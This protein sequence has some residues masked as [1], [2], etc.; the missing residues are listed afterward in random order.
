MHGVPSTR[1]RRRT[2]RWQIPS[3][4]TA[5]LRVERAAAVIARLHHS[6]GRIGVCDERAV[7]FT[8]Q[9]AA[10]WC[11]VRHIRLGIEGPTSRTIH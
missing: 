3:P 2:A 9:G 4:V 7:R 6:R 8:D 5:D 10:L 11:G 1:T